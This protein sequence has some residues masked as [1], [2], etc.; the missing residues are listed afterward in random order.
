MS[1]PLSLELPDEAA[2]TRLGRLL[3]LVLSERLADIAE[4]G[5][6]LRLDGD[7]GA[8]KTA[9]VRA[10][11]R[12]LGV[13]GPV[14]SPTFALVEPYKVSRLDFY[15]FDFYRFADPEE[16]ASAGFREMFGPA[17]IT[18]SE[19][20]ERAGPRL[21][22]ADLRIALAPEGEGRRATISA[23]SPIGKACLSALTISWNS[24]DA[25]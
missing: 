14:K 10:L 6:N 18:A 13:T 22:A 8:G 21:P 24:P 11:L 4:Q 15:H 9:L 1:N 2:T 19:W 20:S 7:L 23:D 16:F 25:V 12:G 3:A 5:F 17:C